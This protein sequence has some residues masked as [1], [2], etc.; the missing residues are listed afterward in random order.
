M[1]PEGLSKEVDFYQVATLLQELDNLVGR[2]ALC[3]G[4]PG[5]ALYGWTTYSKSAK[6]SVDLPGEVPRTYLKAFCQ[7]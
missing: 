7:A 4:R 1:L 5:I 3:T 6:A 2:G